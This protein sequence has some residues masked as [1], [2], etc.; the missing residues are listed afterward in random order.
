MNLI[1]ILLMTVSVLTVLSGFTVLLG[2]QKGKR[3]PVVPYFLT[4]IAAAVWGISMAL[5]ID[6]Q[7]S[8]MTRATTCLIVMYIS[9][10]ADIA[11][12]YWYVGWKKKSTWLIMGIVILATIWLSISLAVDPS[13][14]F[15]EISLSS[16]GNSV[17]YAN[18][19]YFLAYVLLCTAVIIG[20]IVTTW[21]EM[22]K[23]HHK[24]AR[25]GLQVLFYGLLIAGTLGIIFDFIVPYFGNYSL[26]WIGPLASSLAIILHYYAILRYRLI[27]LSSSWLKTLSYAVLMSLGAMVY[28]VIFF[29]IFTAL[30]KIPNPSAS[31]VVLNFIMIVIVLLL[32]PV[33]NEA[34]AYVRSLIMVGQVDI[35]YIVKKLNRL[36]TQNVNLNELADFLA[37]HLHFDYIGFIVDGRLYGSKPLPISADELDE[38]GMLEAA[39]GGIWQ[40]IDGKNKKLFEKLNLKAVAELR[41]AKGRSFGQILV[42]KPVGKMSFERK[43]LIQLE[44]IVNLVASV[45]DS[46]K[47]L[48]V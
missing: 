42:G 24:R 16:K 22:R 23:E 29:I 32:V 39:E 11:M 30:F 9:T 41:N 27:V 17:T 31:I 7:P 8:D 28:M 18:T 35:A 6:T 1:A 25:R 10:L 20:F 4:T 46:E 36:A 15:A 37:D 13:R 38:I 19:L 26:I 40:K 2:A 34:S 47:H 3:A 5:F 21:I 43:D 48:K 33:I 12:L 14:M 44:M 45:I